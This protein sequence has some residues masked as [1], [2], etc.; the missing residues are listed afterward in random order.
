MLVDHIAEAPIR[1]EYRS[2][3]SRT[4]RAKHLNATGQQRENRSSLDRGT[5]TEPTEF[6]SDDSEVRLGLPS[7]D[8]TKGH[9]QRTPVSI[10]HTEA[11][12]GRREARAL[13]RQRH[14]T[15]RRATWVIRKRRCVERK[16]GWQVCL[17]KLSNVAVAAPRRTSAE[18]AST[19]T[20]D[21]TSCAPQERATT[22]QPSASSSERRGS[23][24][25]NTTCRPRIQSV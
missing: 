13:F 7:I 10:D 21:F 4:T 1:R 22:T 12:P 9:R 23:S 24:P 15:S 2:V 5:D 20:I 14:M 17:S 18:S 11:P 25:R 16:N 6:R 3:L 8:I 19:S